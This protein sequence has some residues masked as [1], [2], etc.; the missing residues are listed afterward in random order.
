MIEQKNEMISTKS[1]LVGAQV[2]RQKQQVQKHTIGGKSCMH[3][4]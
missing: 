3:K 2:H 4:T 1:K